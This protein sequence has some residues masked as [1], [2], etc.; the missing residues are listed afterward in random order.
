MQ[1]DFDILDS[2]DVVSNAGN[3][4]KLFDLLSNDIRMA[5]RFD[6]EMK[7]ST[8][9]LSRW[10]QDPQLHRSFGCGPGFE[11]ETCQYT[12]DDDPILQRS[13][14][15]H[16]VVSYRFGGLQCVV[17]SEVDGYC[18]GCDVHPDESDLR[19]SSPAS[20]ATAAAAH[21]KRRSDPLPSP[22]IRKLTGLTRPRSHRPS[23]SADYTL[24]DRDDPGDSPAFTPPQPP[25]TT[26][27]LRIHHTGKRIPASC[28]VE[29][30]THNSR[31]KAK[32]STHQAQMYFSRRS[33]L[34]SASHENRV[35]RPGP[36]L[37]VRDVT[38]ELA[39]WERVQQGRLQQLAAL[40][41]LVREK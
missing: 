31:S 6:I 25:T 28:L 18:C 8:L 12:P 33:Q 11:R 9:L 2:V 5:V 30:K 17:Q 37:L 7:G 22:S 36:G 3:L 14:S 23:R 39:V 20:P 21:K 24:L 40:L 34:F 1:P 32:F 26:P 27:T 35:F 10:N 16:R 29:I 13:I 15:H 4:R 38:Q 19:A 41:R